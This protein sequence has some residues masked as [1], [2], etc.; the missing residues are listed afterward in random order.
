MVGVMNENNGSWSEIDSELFIL[1]GMVAV[2]G[3]DEQMA[4]VAALLPF[5]RDAEFRVVELASG[6]G[7][8]GYTLLDCFPNARLLA[9]DG[10]VV[11]LA[12]ASE[13]LVPY[14]NRCEL[15]EFDL[16]ETDWLERI[17]GAGSVVSSLTIH[18]LSDEGKQQL[19]RSVFERLAPGGAFIIADLVHPQRPEATELFA[20]GWDYMASQQ[21]LIEAGN[22]EPYELFLKERWNHYRYP[23]DM[24]TPS[25]LFDQL[26][27]LSEAGFV[28]VDCF[29]MRAGHAVYGGYKPGGTPPHQ[30]V[31]FETA[32]E[33]AENAIQASI[34]LNLG[35]DWWERE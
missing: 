1:L 11:M 19:F 20:G 34:D 16:M 3:R 22:E 6:Q 7:L 9:L 8:L 26:R 2:P 30:P 17:D 4:T 23:D 10:S 32:L 28:G 5:D 18:H 13:L 35:P 12:K 31:G 25:P 29:W 24:D 21:S 15:A 33:S 14:L 27:W